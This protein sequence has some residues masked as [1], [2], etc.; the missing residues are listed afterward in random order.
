MNVTT[1]TRE[2][3][4]TRYSDGRV[5]R[6]STTKHQLSIPIP[7]GM[8]RDDCEFFNAAFEAIESGDPS[9]LIKKLLFD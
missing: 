8:D 9:Q 2:V 7:G 3:S 5:W 4:S 1:R 6:V